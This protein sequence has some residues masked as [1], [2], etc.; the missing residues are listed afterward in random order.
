MKKIIALLAAVSVAVSIVTIPLSV[1][2]SDVILGDFPMEAQDSRVQMQQGATES[3]FVEHTQEGHTGKYLKASGGNGVTKCFLNESI[4]DGAFEI[5]WEVNSTVA[6]KIYIGGKDENGTDRT[7]AIFSG[8]GEANVW[9]KFKATVVLTPGVDNDSVYAALYDENGEKINEVSTVT[10]AESWNNTT[11]RY[12]YYNF[13]GVD[14]IGFFSNWGSNY[15]SLDNVKVRRTPPTVKAVYFEDGDGSLKE[16]YGDLTGG[17]SGIAFEFTTDIDENSVIAEFENS[18]G[19]ESGAVSKSNGKIIIRPASGIFAVNEDYTLTVKSGATD[20]YGM[21]L[22]EDYPFFFNTAKAYKNAV[23]GSFP[24]EGISSNVKM[25]GGNNESN[26][27]THTEEG[28]T[29]KYMK[30]SGSNGVTRCFINEEISYGSFEI[31]WEVNATNTSNISIGNTND[32]SRSITLFSQLGE[33]GVWN[34]YK[35]LVDIIPGYVN[36]KVNAV[37]YDENGEKLDEVSK[38]TQAAVWNSSLGKDEYFD[39]H[40]INFIGFFSGWNGGQSHCIDNVTVTYSAPIFDKIMFS[41]F[42]GN[43]VDKITELPGLLESVDL[44]FTNDIDMDMS[45]P[46]LY[47][48]T[49][50][51]VE[52]CFIEISGRTIIVYP[53]EGYFAAD[54]EYTVSFTDDIMD[55]YGNVVRVPVSEF[56][57]TQKSGM[58]VAGMRFTENGS[59]I[60]ISDISAGDTIALELDYVFVDNSR[61]NVILAIATRKDGKITGFA[62]KATEISG[63]GKNTAKIIYTLDNDAEYD[64]VCGFVWDKNSRVPLMDELV[65]E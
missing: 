65:I 22:Q 24:M 61:E 2:A 50:G 28:H 32:N 17:L 15:H 55:S 14:F 12:D 16:N 9:E 30:A 8:L 37:L 18:D 41:D 44:M 23:L 48:E 63:I 54:N 26:Y 13:H 3:N 58:G 5:E 20:S 38:V 27:L 59:E 46:E 29:G 52:D 47:N 25:Q 62:H 19:T 53:S 40:G 33:A 7:I 64:S 1:S 49:T 56:F 45:A 31:E 21:E 57:V 6:S 39:F 43:R 10:R 34:K 35:V 11:M 4:S 42:E 60:G 36:D 51:S